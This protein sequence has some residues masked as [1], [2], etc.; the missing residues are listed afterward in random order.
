MSADPATRYQNAVHW[1]EQYVGRNVGPKIFRDLHDPRPPGTAWCAAM[2]RDV[3]LHAG[4][5]TP[6]TW[7]AV[8]NI[9]LWA[10]QHGA[11][12]MGIADVQPGDI[13]IHDTSSEQHIGIALDAARGGSFR[14]IAGNSASHNHEM[15]IQNIPGYWQMHIRARDVISRHVVNGAISGGGTAAAAPV[16]T[17]AEVAGFHWEALLHGLQFV[18]EV[19]VGIEVA[20]LLTH[21][22]EENV[23]YLESLYDDPVRM[24]SDPWLQ[25]QLQI[26]K[27]AGGYW[28]G[29]NRTMQ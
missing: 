27:M 20:A 2:V 8:H 1:A 14:S 29:I 28:P 10:Q 16:Q 19:V 7:D 24:K 23:R 12:V 17:L 13:L 25:A 3:L 15:A 11:L 26:W 9:R 18:A 6:Q 4:V 22:N 5:K 21:A